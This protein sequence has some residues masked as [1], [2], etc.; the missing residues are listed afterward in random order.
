MTMTMIVVIKIVWG[1]DICPRIWSTMPAHDKWLLIT[2]LSSDHTA[3]APDITVMMQQHS[4]P[5]EYAIIWWKYVCKED[6]CLDI[7]DTVLEWGL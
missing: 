7:V 3:P 2:D 1:C 6:F 5:R 4:H